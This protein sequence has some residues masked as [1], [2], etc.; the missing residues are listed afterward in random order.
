[1][2]F[3]TNLTPWHWLSLAVLFLIAEMLGFSGFLIG[4]AAAAFVT[5]LASALMDFSWQAQVSTFASL[6]IVFTIAYFRFF[7]EFTFRQEDHH[8]LHDRVSQQVGKR[9]KVVLANAGLVVQIGDTFWPIA[10]QADGWQEG[11]DVLVEGR[12][13]ERLKIRKV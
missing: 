12:E 1:M 13:A 7:R 8:G 5:G 2:D 6:A 9:G 10:N 3:V 11:D 4:A